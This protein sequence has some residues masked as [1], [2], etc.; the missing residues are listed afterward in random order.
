MSWRKFKE[1]FGAGARAEHYFILG[2]DIGNATSSMSY[3][4]LN[5]ASAEIIDISGGYGKPSVP[6][7]MQYINETKEWVFGEYAMAGRANENDRVFGALIE[8]L[9]A[10][11]Y[12]EVAGRPLSVS[13]VLALYLKE[14]IGN[15]KNIN[16]RAEIAGIV[17]SVPSY[18]SEEARKDL[19]AVFQLAGYEKQLMGFWDD[20]ECIF[21]RYYFDKPVKQETALIIDFGA[22][23]IRGGVY[24]I[25]PGED[26]ARVD[27]QSFLIEKNL[28]TDH[29]D[30][31]VDGL[32]TALYAGHF[33]MTA[34]DIPPRQKEQ[35]DLFAYQHKD[36]LFQKRLQSKPVKLY[37]N[38]AYPPFQET[39]TYDAIEKTIRPFRERFAAFI[40]EIL[41]KPTASGKT[42]SAADI[43]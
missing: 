16:P 40:R 31:K 20:R 26:G 19:A 28:G 22:R 37:F 9:G 3:F 43:D 23:E 41:Q 35:I 30:K 12:V 2:I 36:M 33:G 38:F 7:V 25:A 34:E 10:G 24:E 29:I 4:D 8:R 13:A 6:T 5:Q 42:L 39:V 15:C 27:C 32:F 1:L 21:N 14:L 18:L 11:D 17:V